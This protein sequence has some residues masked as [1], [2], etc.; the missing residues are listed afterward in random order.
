M[1]DVTDYNG[2]KMMNISTIPVVFGKDVALLVAFLS[3]LYQSNLLLNDNYY[4]PLALFQIPAFVNIAE[5][6]Q[7]NYEKTSIM[8]YSKDNHHLLFG[9]L[10]AMMALTNA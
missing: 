8:K 6:K 5:I 9:S 3:L 1:L 2:D 7:S 10:L 4:Y